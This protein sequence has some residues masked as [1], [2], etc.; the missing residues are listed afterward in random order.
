MSARF[1][2]P[3]D[4]TNGFAG[5]FCPGSLD[6][7]PRD[8]AAD[9]FRQIPHGDL[10]GA[11]RFLITARAMYLAGVKRGK[12]EKTLADYVKVPTAR[13]MLKPLLTP[14]PDANHVSSDAKVGALAVLAAAE[15]VAEAI[16][17]RSP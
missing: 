17:N 6:S 16:L 13:V 3:E 4:H 14:G 5:A 9:W 8:C 11:E 1:P 2:L 12:D 7:P 10:L 15:L